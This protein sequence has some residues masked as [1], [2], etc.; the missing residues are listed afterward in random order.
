[1]AIMH[2]K[3]ILIRMDGTF[4][5]T[6]VPSLELI[7]HIPTIWEE[8]EVK[9]PPKPWISDSTDTYSPVCLSPF[10]LKVV[11]RHIMD[12][13]VLKVYTLQEN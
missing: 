9:F 6:R 8:V 2:L 11:D 10:F 3:T 5:L 4:S 12:D 1:M 7:W 13:D